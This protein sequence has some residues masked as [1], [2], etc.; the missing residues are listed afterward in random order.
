[1]D[2]FIFKGHC[3]RLSVRYTISEICYIIH[4]FQDLKHLCFA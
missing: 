3:N 2:D 4:A 1:M